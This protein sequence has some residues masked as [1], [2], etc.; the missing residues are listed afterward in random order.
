MKFAPSP[1]LRRATSLAGLAVVAA[2]SLSATAGAAVYWGDNGTV[3]AARPDGGDVNPDYFKPPFPADS[4]GPICGVAVSASYLYWAGGFGIGRVNLEGPAAPQT[5]VSGLRSPCGLAVDAQHVYWAEPGADRIGRANLDGS[6]ATPSFISGLD[7][8]CGLAVDGSRVYWMG[9]RGVGTAN[10]DGSEADSEYLA[11][12][13][14][15]CGLAVDGTHLYWGQHGAIGRA[16]L[17]AGDPEPGFVTG[18][19]S[20]ESIAV[21]AGHVYW[22][23]RPEGM[24]FSSV[25]R[26]GI[27][28]SEAT[29]SWIPTDEFSLGGVAVDAR[30]APVAL[31]LPSGS[32]TFGKVRHR[33]G[34]GTVVID[35]WVPRRGQL[36]LVSPHLGWRVLTGPPPPAH[37]EGGF[38]WRLKLWP[39]RSDFGRRVRAQLRRRGRARLTLRVS[40]AET[41]Q[42]PVERTKAIALLGRR[43]PRR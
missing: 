34:R 40:Y 17:D 29:R 26:V 21:D 25:G 1:R 19:G 8:P 31:P 22:T 43:S 12:G 15:G 7:G 20:V 35:V 41:G 37:V 6:A 10:L 11:A 32:F 13:A 18:I 42:L 16:G 23:D 39:G 28:G 27:E 2:L 5:I 36:T 33:P 3:G 30:P 14:S 4:A 38:R 24:S 9:W